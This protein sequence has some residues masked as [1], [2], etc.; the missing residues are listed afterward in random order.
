[1]ATLRSSKASPPNSRSNQTKDPRVITSDRLR[2]DM[3]AFRKAGGE[4]EKLGN[5]QSLKK[6]T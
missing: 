6:I 3:E 2:A 4:I 5:T 1:M